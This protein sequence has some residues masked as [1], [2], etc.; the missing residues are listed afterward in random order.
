[1]LK[2]PERPLS[3]HIIKPKM[4]MTPEQTANQ[5]RQTAEGGA[6]MC[7]DDEM[8]ADASSGWEPLYAYDR[9]W[10][11]EVRGRRWLQRGVEGVMAHPGLRDRLLPLLGASGALDGIVR[12]T[13]DLPGPWPA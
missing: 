3:L 2:V 4:G 10:S 12:L 6:D 7:K 5:V 8:L 13:G 11:G 9:Q 1:M